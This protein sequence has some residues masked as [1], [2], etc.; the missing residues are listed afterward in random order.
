[1]G[2]GGYVS[3][4]IPSKTERGMFY[5]RPDVGGAY[6]WEKQNKRWVPLL[7]WVSEADRGYMS[8]ESM[9]VD[10]R[11]AANISLMVGTSYFNGGK[12]TILHSSAYGQSFVIV[13]IT[14]QFKVHGNGW[15]RG[16]GEKLQVDPG[17]S[18]VLYAG[19]RG[20]GLFRSTDAGVTWNRLA[21]LPVTSTA[22]GSGI[23]FVLLDPASVDGGP[24][25][26]I[27]VCVSR[28]DSAEIGRAACRERV[29]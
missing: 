3:G 4:V 20:D 1:M 8:V 29:L 21:S 10:P 14:S 15:G 17:D 19:S 11:N 18:R 23:G 7:D 16:N 2:G 24:A 12:S 6:R 25:Q 5:A 26:R 9:A 28:L 22:N 27:F 13:D